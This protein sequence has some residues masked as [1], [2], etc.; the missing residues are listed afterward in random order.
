MP[1][2]IGAKCTL[3]SKFDVNNFNREIKNMEIDSKDALSDLE[4]GFHLQSWLPF[5]T[6]ILEERMGEGFILCGE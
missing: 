2:N 3:K 1:E 4:F 5:P 6:L